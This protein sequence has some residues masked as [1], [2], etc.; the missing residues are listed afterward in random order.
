MA[1]T[2]PKA[3][4]YFNVA[5]EYRYDLAIH[6]TRTTMHTPLMTLPGLFAAQERS[7]WIAD[8][9]NSDAKITLLFVL[10]SSVVAVIAILA[11]TAVKIHRRNTEVT[12]KR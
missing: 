4:Q 7:N 8:G 12:L 5:S 11:G 3:K 10:S 1:E 9:L 6:P 2:W